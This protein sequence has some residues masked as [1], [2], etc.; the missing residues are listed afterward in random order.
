MS[1]F[2]H[3]MIIAQGSS[4]CRVWKKS[5]IAWKQLPYWFFLRDPQLLT[6]YASVMHASL[7]HF[8]SEQTDQT[9]SALHFSR[10]P[11]TSRPSII[12]A[13]LSISTKTT[14]LLLTIYFHQKSGIAL[15]DLTFCW[16]PWEH[17]SGLLGVLGRG[18]KARG[19]VSVSD[20]RGK[21]FNLSRCLP[22]GIW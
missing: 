4:E 2:S 18:N 20:T 19:G 17:P 6:S 14:K 9:N 12:H 22:F 5:V 16:Y 10:R 13:S 1:W 11:P 8:P 21:S 15:G 7:Y 3:R